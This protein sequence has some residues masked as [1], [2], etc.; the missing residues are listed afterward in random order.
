MK[1]LIISA[2]NFEDTELLVSYYRML[3]EGIEVEVASLNKGRIKGK[4]G[5][6][7]D[8]SLSF[9][10]VKPQ[11]Y[12]ILIIPGGK[13]PEAIRSNPDVIRIVHH[14]FDAAKTVAAI[15]HG[16]QV[17]ISAGVMEGKHA[18][19]Y[20]SVALELKN[21]GVLYEDVAVITDGNLI[22][23]RKPADLPAFMRE[24]MKKLKI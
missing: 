23:S 4:K 24:I 9:A 13:A 18:T 12:D 8:V 1:C 20:P 5:H 15:C 19:S 2:D 16:P 6:E 11:D 3:E 22:T 10:E 14:F 7:I 17:L 21:A